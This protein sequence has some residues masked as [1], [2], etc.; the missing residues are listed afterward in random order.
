MAR[1]RPIGVPRAFLALSV[2]QREGP[3]WPRRQS[4]RSRRAATFAL[5]GIALLEV[6]EW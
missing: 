5:L 4:A 3:L 6:V 1:L 2:W